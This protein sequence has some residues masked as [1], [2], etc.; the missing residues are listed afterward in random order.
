MNFNNLSI[1]LRIALGLSLVLLLALLS[2]GNTLYQNIRVKFETAQVSESWVPAIDNLGGM[3]DALSDHYLL[4]SDRL[5]GRNT[6]DAAQFA[7]RVQELDTRLSRA[8]DIYAATLESYLP[9]DPQADQEKALY[10]RY[11]E[12]RDAY[13]SAA[14]SALASGGGDVSSPFRPAL[15]AVDKIL[16]FNLAGTTDAAKRAASLVR[17]AEWTMLVTT[18]VVMLVGGLLIWLIPN[19]VVRPVQEAV[20]VAHQ[21]A[22]GDLTRV[23]RTDRKDELGALLSSLD[24]MQSRLKDL[25]LAL[26][27][28]AEQVSG[29]SSEIE[30]GN[31]DL[32]ARTESQA[33]ALEQTSASMSELGSTVGQ[34]AQAAREADSLVREAAHRAEAGGQVVE[35]VVETMRGISDS[36]QKIGD[37]IGVIDG[38]A[39]QTNILALNAAVEAARAGEQGRGFAVVASE[40][41]TLAQRSADAAKQIKQLIDDSTAR[42]NQGAA[43][44]SRAGQSM[45]DIVASVQQITGIVAQISA[46]SNDQAQGVQQVSEAVTQIDRSTQQN[47]ALVEEMAAAASGLRGQA[48]QLV[49]LAATFKT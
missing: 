36:S 34:N 29:S 33:S 14:K 12:S 40:V 38:I 49:Q 31:H 45:S 5:A 11:R 18:G 28:Q 32:S 46:A 20:A 3:K 16:A 2:A 7:V 27:Q 13:F 1:R 4:A 25:A 19:S 9:G 42:V 44:V 47:A 41:R 22:Q 17:S 10:A 24:D 48:Q 43:Q 35:T 21:I 6:E 8:T 26:R 39:F 30:Q 37:I 23:I 15:G